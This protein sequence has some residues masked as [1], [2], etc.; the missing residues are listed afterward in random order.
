MQSKEYEEDLKHQ[1]TA[2]IWRTLDE[3]EQALIES[4]LEDVKHEQLLMVTFSR[5]A[6]SEFKK[7][8]INLIGGAAL[9]VDIKTFHS[10]VPA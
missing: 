9:F 2:R 4:E 8:L 7:R 6:A 5:A 3:D 1:K 10:F